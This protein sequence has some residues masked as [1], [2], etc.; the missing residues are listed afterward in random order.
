MLTDQDKPATYMEAMEGPESE[1]WLEAM[2]SKIRSMYDNQ[3]WTFEDI[4]SDRK[5]IENKWILKKKTDADGN[6][7]IYKAWLVVKGF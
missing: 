3:V 6:V 5:A 7:T 4:P 1:E 2:K